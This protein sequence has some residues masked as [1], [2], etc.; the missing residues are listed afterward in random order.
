VNDGLPL[1]PTFGSG[2]DPLGE[3]SSDPWDFPDRVAGPGCD[4]ASNPRNPN[5]YIKTK[6]FSIP[7]A[8][9]MAFW[10]AN[11]DPTPPI[12]PKGALVAV[13]FPQ[14]F[15]LRGNVGRNILR[16]PGLI[17]LDTSLFK[18]NP[19]PRISESFNAQFRFEVF[20]VLNR[21]NFQLPVITNDN[22]FT[23]SGGLDPN[24]GVITSTVTTSR[25]LQL[26]LKIIW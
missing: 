15:N 26:A 16:G 7:S 25:Q 4:T 3:K 20:N 13:P 19:I 18:N 11:C 8:P 24:G 17:N 14:C 2:G 12:G 5:N 9:S 6:C 1:T 23:A 10:T 21:A 22:I